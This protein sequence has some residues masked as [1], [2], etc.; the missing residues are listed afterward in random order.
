MHSHLL[1]LQCSTGWF[2]IAL[3][4]PPEPLSPQA[5]FAQSPHPGRPDII[6][7]RG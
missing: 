2:D 5:C 1:Q 3:H 7:V 6:E 4:A